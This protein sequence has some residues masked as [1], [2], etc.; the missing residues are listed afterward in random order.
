M[1]GKGDG[2]SESEG[3]GET[4]QEFTRDCRLSQAM[5]PGWLVVA[6]TA[7]SCRRRTYIGARGN[8]D[9]GASDKHASGYIAPLPQTRTSSSLV[10]RYGTVSDAARG[11]DCL[12]RAAIQ[13][14]HSEPVESV[15]TEAA[16]GSSDR[17][18]PKSTR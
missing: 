18:V 9:I 12:E 13:T 16:D 4:K 11:K 3:E 10:G 2:E 14:R 8:G 1:E 7:A 17:L 5:L 15:K 6:S